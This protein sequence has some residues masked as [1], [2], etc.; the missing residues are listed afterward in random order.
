LGTSI[1][2]PTPQRINGLDALRLD[3]SGAEADGES[4]V[5]LILAAAPK[6]PGF[7]ALCYWGDD[8]AQESVGADLQMIAESLRAAK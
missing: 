7:V 1:R 8:E 5:T 4:Y 6:G 3:Y 2:R